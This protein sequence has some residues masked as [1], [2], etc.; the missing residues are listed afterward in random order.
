MCRSSMAFVSVWVF[1]LLSFGSFSCVRAK[2]CYSCTGEGCV[3]V[4]TAGT[5]VTCAGVDDLCYSKFDPT[6]LLPIER[7]C[8]TA[9]SVATCTGD[10]CVSCSTVDL[11]NEQSS[12]KHRCAVCSSLVDSGCL[13]TPGSLSD[14][15][16]PAPS[17]VDLTQAQCYSRVVGNVTER[18]CITSQTERDQ[19]TD[20]SCST[21]TGVGCNRDVFPVGRAQCIQCDNANTCN[22][23]STSA[24]YCAD[25]TDI[26]V[27]LRR[28]NGS[29]LKSCEKAAPQADLNNYRANAT[30]CGQTLCNTGS[31]NASAVAKSCY[32]C[33]GTG[34]LKSVAQLVTCPLLDDDCFSKFSGFNPIQRGCTSELPQDET[35]PAP[36]C[37]ICLESECNLDA[38]S[39]HRCAYCSS[40]KDAN[41]INPAG[42]LNI[43]QCP[44]PTTDVTNAQCYTKIIN[45]AITERGCISSESDLQG[46]A[47]DGSN[48]AT[49]DIS[50][51]GE[52]CNG[53]VFP[54]DRRRCTIG[55][56]PDSYCANPWDDCVQLLQDGVR[57]RTCRSS[58][59][60]S[61]RSF[62]GNNT[63]RCSFCAIDNCNTGEIDFNYVECLSCDSTVDA[64][65]AT[66]PAALNTFERCATCASALITTNSTHVSTRRGCLASL[67]ANVSAQCST[68]PGSS[69]SCLR[70]ST[71]RC[72]V[73][74]FPSDRLQC[75][76]CTDPPCS[77][78]EAIT[79]TYCPQYRAN[80][81]CMLLSDTS[82]QLLRLD[83]SSSL[84]TTEL[85]ACSSGLCQTCRTA[86]CNDPMAYSTSGSCVQ[87]S[88]TLNAL[89]RTQPTAVG[90]EPC[91]NPS[92]TACYSRLTTEGATERGCVS[93]LTT[94]EQSA[95]ARAENCITCS[96]RT[97][98][99]NN[100]QYPV[101][102][103]ACYQCD[104]RTN[105]DAC[106]AAQ[107][108][109]ATECAP[110]NTA[111]K[112][113]T[114]VQ[115]N[116]DTV[117]KCST[118][119][120]EVECGSVGACE[121]CLF[122]G[123]NGKAS[124][125]VVVTEPPV[126][127]TTPGPFSGALRQ[128]SDGQLALIAALATVL[129]CFRSFK[130]L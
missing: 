43:V 71:N 113:F 50:S 81:S 115:S 107:T 103:L 58:L 45:E 16:C 13:A 110:Y 11:C 9:S 27:T 52:G 128:T 63:N 82:G 83:C 53:D 6:S 72:N 62:C 120:R 44:A 84:T 54:S 55:T 26:C 29:V 86:A 80:D 33:E 61:E 76:R 17:S 24:V 42:V 79:L 18:G 74:N 125:A 28:P 4:S 97:T 47:I 90:A 22:T 7:G 66:N 121:V 111:N 36:E 94:S 106:K 23:D 127:T 59:T 15:Q 64:R 93:D 32:Q 99:C 41:C 12:P 101:A 130:A 126:Q 104:S 31:Y 14:V 56:Q 85:A 49:C 100:G 114:I 2:D 10:E 119:S 57:K 67:P 98:D 122:S 8:L 91:L 89:C 48:C 38:R 21:C 39:D 60:E 68:T 3:R 108:G 34:C 102:P 25:P 40:I 92:N 124:T 116:G 20:S 95:C 1:V 96:S 75:Y 105:G 77:S 112:C 118:A 37:S 65:C 117:R 46:C 70:C 19:C 30:F 129:W 5:V 109:T 69:G 51:S 88:S 73:A 35:C 123:C 87:C 78:H